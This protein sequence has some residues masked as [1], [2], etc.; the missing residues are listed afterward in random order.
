MYVYSIVHIYIKVNE[1]LSNTSHVVITNGNK[2]LTTVVHDG[3]AG[4]Y[5]V[6]YDGLLLQPLW[7]D[8]A[9][10]H[11]QTGQIFS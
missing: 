3:D 9:R 6:R 2:I 1:L 4:V 8:V 11:Y 7:E 10:L 5:E